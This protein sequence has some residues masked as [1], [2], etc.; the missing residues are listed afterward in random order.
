MTQA[1][2]TEIG[3]GIP[4]IRSCCVELDLRLVEFGLTMKKRSRESRDFPYAFRLAVNYIHDV[5]REHVTGIS[6]ARL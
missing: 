1:V 6:C 3:A 2:E 4:I 5:V